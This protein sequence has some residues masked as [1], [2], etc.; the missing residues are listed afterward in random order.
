[1][2]ERP[3]KIRIMGA[4]PT[5]IKCPSCEEDIAIPPPAVVS[6]IERNELICTCGKTITVL[7]TGR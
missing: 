7:A 2:P 5:V 4:K 6:E 3:I 1:M